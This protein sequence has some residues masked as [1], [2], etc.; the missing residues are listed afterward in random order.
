[1]KTKSDNRRGLYVNLN[2]EEHEMLNELRRKH[3]LNIAGFIK[4]CLKDKF[5]ELE[6][7]KK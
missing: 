7:D 4:Q 6:K 2:K 3:F 1:M 5:D